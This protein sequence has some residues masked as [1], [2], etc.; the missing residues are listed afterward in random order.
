VEAE[1][2]NLAAQFVSVLPDIKR[3]ERYGGL[4]TE[5]AGIYKSQRLLTVKLEIDGMV[6]RMQK[7]QTAASMLQQ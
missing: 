7:G 1:N 3:V 4:A 5:L 6:L 2:R